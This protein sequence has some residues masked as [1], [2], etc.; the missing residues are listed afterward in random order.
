MKK[1]LVLLILF[2]PVLL[3]ACSANDNGE[4]LRI[5]IRAN[6]NS[7]IDQ[8]VKYYIKDVV[9]TYLSPLVR[10]CK[11]KAEAVNVVSSHLDGI[12]A[13][14]DV[15]L[16]EKGLGYSSSAKINNEFFP[17]KSYEE[18]TLESGYYDAL[19]INLGSGS[20]NNWWCVMYPNICFNEPK[21]VVYRSK[22]LE[23][24][25]KVLEGK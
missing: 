3:G 10:D 11:S 7:E 25:Q 20:G 16:N 8:E 15:A 1:L 5:H 23:I 4:Y 13:V 18:L 14:V 2:C 21:N 17:T 24:I 9:V 6:S 19:I 12:E 22:I